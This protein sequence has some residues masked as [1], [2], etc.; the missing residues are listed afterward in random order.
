MVSKLTLT[1]DDLAEQIPF[2]ATIQGG[3]AYIVEHEIFTNGTSHFIS[4]VG[5]KY[6]FEEIMHVKFPFLNPKDWYDLNH[7]Y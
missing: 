1:E 2:T 3:R 4:A 7:D 5:N 6:T